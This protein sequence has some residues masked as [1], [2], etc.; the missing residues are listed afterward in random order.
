MIKASEVRTLLKQQRD[1]ETTSAAPHLAAFSDQLLTDIESLIVASAKAQKLAVEVNIETAVRA[2]MSANALA[3]YA[4]FDI[5]Y[6]R[7]AEILKSLGSDGYLVT[8][9]I[10]G[11]GVIDW[12]HEAPTG[13]TTANIAGEELK[14]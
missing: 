9:G 8:M 4:I 14:S 1:T 13:E 7:G 2:Y 11:S 6:A 5:L 10:F 3:G 12:T